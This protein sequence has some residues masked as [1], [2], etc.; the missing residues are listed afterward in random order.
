MS[1]PQQSALD[2]F[3]SAT[4]LADAISKWDD[5]LSSTQEDDRPHVQVKVG[6]TT[7]N[8]LLDSGSQ[9]SLIRH[10][11]LKLITRSLTV[12]V[13]KSDKTLTGAG[14]KPLPATFSV[15]LPLEVNAEK[16][17]WKIYVSNVL[18]SPA[19]FGYDLIKRLNIVY[20]P[21]N[22]RV[23]DKA[24]SMIS[25][26]KTI[27]IP[28]FCICVTEVTLQPSLH[29][30]HTTFVIES[31]AEGKGY[32][33]PSII[34]LPAYGKNI[35]VP[36][37]NNSSTELCIAAR[38]IVAT[39]T[40]PWKAA[41]LPTLV[42]AVCQNH[43]QARSLKTPPLS[44]EK[45]KLLENID[46][47][48]V[49][50]PMKQKFKQLL[51]EKHACFSAHR[52]DLGL[53]PK[54]S[55]DI[56]LLDKNQVPIFQKQYKPAE[57]FREKLLEEIDSLYKHGIIEHAITKWSSPLFCVVK[58]SGACRIVADLRK[59]NSVCAEH[60]I[61]GPSCEDMIEVVGRQ[62]AQWYS[63]ADIKNAYWQ[64]NL[65][66]KYRDLTA[67]Y[68][69][70]RGQFR[71]TRVP[72]GLASSPAIFAAIV[73][74]VIRDCG[75]THAYLDDLLTTSRSEV[76]HFSHLEKLF[77]A[78]IE[79]HM[80]LGPDK[81]HF[82]KTEVNYL[83]FVLSR[84]G[85][86]PAI[87]KTKV[88][89][90]YPPPSTRKQILQ[91]CGL[92]N[93]YRKWIKNFSLLSQQMTALCKKNSGWTGGELPPTALAAFRQLQYCLTHAPI[94]RFADYDEPFHL[95]VDASTGTWSEKKPITLGGLGAV[96]TQF[97][98][99]T[100]QEQVIAYASRGLLKH[101][102][103]YPPI[104]LEALACK[105]GCK[106]F[107][108]IL[109]GRRFFLYTDH[110]PLTKLSMANERTL[111]RLAEL[112]LEYDYV[113]VYKPGTE[114][115]LADWCSRAASE[116][117]VNVITT[118]NVDYPS[119][120][121]LTVTDLETLQTNDDLC[122]GVLRYLKLRQLPNDRTLAQEILNVARKSFIHHNGLLFH[123][124]APADEEKRLRALLFAPRVL[125]R[126]YLRLSHDSPL[127]GHR[128]LAK[129]LARLQEYC[130]WPTQ[131]NDCAKWIWSC[132]ICQKCRPVVKP[133][134]SPIIPITQSKGFNRR[135]HTD[136]FGPLALSEEYKYVLII[137]D[138]FTKYAIFEPLRNKE[139]G[140]VSM[141]LYRRWYTKFGAADVVIS[142]RGGEF[143][144]EVTAQMLILM[145]STHR[146]TT[147]YHPQSNST[148]E[149]LCKV[150]KMYLMSL[151][152]HQVSGWESYLPAL[153]MCYN[154]S[155]HSQ[156]RVA[157]FKS[158]FGYRPVWFEPRDWNQCESILYSEN[159]GVDIARKIA[160]AQQV[161][162]DNNIRFRTA[163]ERCYN[164]DKVMPQF[165]EN[166]LFLLHDP[167][168]GLRRYKRKPTPKLVS[169][170]TGPW[171]AS[172]VNTSN[173]TLV[174]LMPGRRPAAQRVSFDRVKLY[175]EREHGPESLYEMIE[176]DVTPSIERPTTRSAKSKE[177]NFHL[178]ELSGTESENDDPEYAEGD[179]PMTPSSRP[180]HD[181]TESSTQVNDDA[182]SPSRPAEQNVLGR[183]DLQNAENAQFIPENN[184]RASEP[185]LSPL[186][187]AE[188]APSSPS[189]PAQGD[190]GNKDPVVTA[191]PP[192]VQEGQE[193]Q[194][195][196][197]KPLSPWQQLSRA[198]AYLSPQKWNTRS[199]RSRGP[200]PGIDPAFK[201]KN[202]RKDKG[203]KRGPRKKTDEPAP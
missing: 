28:P 92:G 139:A 128:G 98:K 111:N 54:T 1:F 171:R 42:E 57:C 72:Q 150:T 147:S 160:F 8:W 24:E 53:Y 51:I 195:G 159:E 191:T 65:D 114:N 113:C 166:Q 82:F 155:E 180:I 121:G 149:N 47:G 48:P 110:K 56:Q 78:L 16:F 133:V 97:N 15:I 4:V 174:L 157:P 107:D 178:N 79:N 71:W 77:D 172:K 9:V 183:Q 131:R 21:R 67:F 93:Y 126:E 17:P 99:N 101:E 31:V 156:T 140:S 177:K 181:N 6:N 198:A 12:K 80:K 83:G 5:V 87:D 190:G 38:S 74:C 49:S 29:E 129:T 188:T 162:R 125:H 112:K 192:G 69:F 22:L 20:N 116:A 102:A 176:D 193:E 184:S 153:E 37:C 50:E 7:L 120:F 10:S 3:N 94:L 163:F 148:S 40:P 186:L 115:T 173:K 89:R 130:F 182:I 167:F 179:E 88:I 152:D 103:S 13:E 75:N 39:G 64:I 32:I 122:A 63:L 45:R 202:P 81:C 59:L 52:H 106:T 43:P 158:V 36:I 124:T 170:W 144:S 141:G 100:G 165:K 62:G 197:S 85:V 86:I 185:A 14:E 104:L 73:N 119:I 2:G 58:K 60:K 96:L 84:E 161:A 154:S 203:I 187:Q 33:P 25:T 138:S 200:A 146:Q 91:F 189:T 108:H 44:T 11:V 109:R 134:K 137:V 61:S 27:K 90:E 135:I 169:P 123:T 30:H 142:D 168:S 34:A 18:S 19:I 105:F 143:L 46:I 175:N 151:C 95:S 194:S 55:H 41:P 127:G 68:V 76:E 117:N 70:G 35:E 201:H 145:G 136:I 66:P 132:D 118:S 23:I 199:S 26:C 196:P 164:K